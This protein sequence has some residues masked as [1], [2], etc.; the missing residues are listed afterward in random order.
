MDS[1]ARML[2]LSLRVWKATG[3]TVPSAA[4]LGAV[5]GG[6]GVDTPRS[7]ELGK[8]WEQRVLITENQ[9]EHTSAAD[10]YEDYC[11]WCEVNDFADSYGEIDSFSRALLARFPQLR[12]RRARVLT[13]SGKITLYKGIVF[14]SWEGGLHD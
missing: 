1:A 6:R 7:V 12:K 5:P 11:V 2:G 4:G 13:A 9:D 3:R 10:L 8:W 14:N